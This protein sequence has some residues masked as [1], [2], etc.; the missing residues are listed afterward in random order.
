VDY[1]RLGDTDLTVSRL[2]L[3]TAPLG[4]LFG[5]VDEAAA[6]GVVHEALELGITFIDTSSSYGNAE[7]LLGKALA[8]RRRDVVLATKAG[9]SG[10]GFDFS[11]EGLRRSLDESLR[12]LRTDHV[13]IFQLHN[14]EFA[15]LERLFADSFTELVSLREQGKCRYIGMT[16]YPAPA[17]IRAFRETEL[18]VSLSYAHATLLDDTLQREIAPVARDQHVG[19]MNA[20]TLA[21]GLLTP[22]GPA[23]PD[24]HPASAPIR[25]AARRMAGLC[26]DRGADIAFVANQ[27]SIH[28]CDCVTTVIGTSNSHHLRSAVAAAETAVDEELLQALL[29]L[30]PPV[31][32]RT[33]TSGLAENNVITAV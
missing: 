13:D 12:R 10:S 15:D 22:G 27:Y 33:W 21:L 1:A 19:L 8:G 23:N 29:G 5:S 28:R 30:R 2:A 16:G 32:E 11:P 17:M 9:R 24:S 7:E 6:I 25:E 4:G 26:A 3:G 20:A 18:D 14:I 31:D